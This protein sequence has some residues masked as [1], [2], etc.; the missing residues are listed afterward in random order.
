MRTEQWPRKLWVTT[1]FSCLAVGLGATATSLAL[2]H[3]RTHHVQAHHA[4]APPA[5]QPVVS[6]VAPAVVQ[7]MGVFRRPRTAS[8]AVPRL[9]PSPDAVVV[10]Q[11]GADAQ[12]ARR[13]FTTKSGRAVYLIP[14]AGPSVCLATA[15]AT[16]QF[17]APLSQIDSGQ[18]F[19]SIV[20]APR[21]PGFTANTIEIAG[22]L[23]DG[24]SGAAF[25][26]SDGSRVSVQIPGGAYLMDFSRTGQLPL[27]FDW[28]GSD[29]LRH[30]VTPLLPPDAASA[31]CP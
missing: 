14:A 17:C 21:L 25:V 18:A 2:A 6:S 26:L 15:P 11:H 10:Y 28:Q 8:D 19:E 3:P 24:A 9:R 29:G 30:R 12:L 23:P 20:C 13:A 5:R 27:E 16:L 31:P 1:A 7:T 4:V 22:M